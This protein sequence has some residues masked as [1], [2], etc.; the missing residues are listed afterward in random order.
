MPSSFA[1]LT[2]ALA[3]GCSDPFSAMFAIFSKSFS[4]LFS[5]VIMSVTE[6]SP[7]VRVP[8][9]S[10]TTVVMLRAFSK[11]CA[12][13]IRIPFSAP[14]PVPTIIAVGVANPKEQGHA[15]INTAM[16]VLKE[17]I[18][19]AGIEINDKNFIKVN[20]N[21][22]TNLPG[23][24]ASGD[25]TGSFAQIVVAAAEGAEAATNAYLYLRGGVYGDKK[26]ADY[27]EKK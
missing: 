13:L 7:F 17:K 21:F 18:K 23:V 25:V 1:F 11:A 6:D 2:M 16:K 19:A 9:L 20:Q 10:N 8:V 24:F 22:E 12:S 27:G 4:V 5:R 14:L 26:P 15:M 3:I